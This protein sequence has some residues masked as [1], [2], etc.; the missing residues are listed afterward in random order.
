MI[1]LPSFVVLP[2]YVG[3]KSPVAVFLRTEMC[4]SA[5]FYQVSRQYMYPKC[6]EKKADKLRQEARFTTVTPV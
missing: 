3:H 5:V 1:T 6:A 2:V 4:G